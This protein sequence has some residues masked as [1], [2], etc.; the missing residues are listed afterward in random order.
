MGFAAGLCAG[1]PRIPHPVKLNVTIHGRSEG[2]DHAE[3]VRVRTDSGIMVSRAPFF[4][5]VPLSP[6]T[7]IANSLFATGQD[8]L[9]IR[10]P[11][12]V[13]IAADCFHRNF[14]NSARDHALFHV[15]MDGQRRQAEPE[16]LD[17]ER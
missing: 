12:T 11:N 3:G 13:G 6:G 16:V 9:L 1:N 4:M 10:D 14:N 15:F 17:F 5:T 8:L 7:R 2:C